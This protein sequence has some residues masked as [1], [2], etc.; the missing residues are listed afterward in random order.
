MKIQKIV[1]AATISAVLALISSDLYA[2]ELRVEVITG[3][4]DLRSGSQFSLRMET[5]TGTRVFSNINRGAG[6][7]NGGRGSYIIDV[8]YLD[9]PTDLFSVEVVHHS[10][11]CFAC[12]Y[13]NWNLSSIVIK[14]TGGYPLVSGGPHRFKG[15]S[16]VLYIPV[17]EF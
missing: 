13:D 6:I 4:D 3:G 17:V 15:S 14:T 1:S 11:S 10:G 9:T 16:P 7:P 2:K 12:S 5:S 8:P